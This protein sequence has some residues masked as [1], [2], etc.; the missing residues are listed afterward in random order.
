[1]D[2]KEKFTF[3]YTAPTEEERREIDGIRRQYSPAAAENDKLARLRTLDRRV[4]R[5]P[6]AAALTASII[7][8]LVFGTGLAMVLEWELVLGGVI[9]AALGAA[10]AAT[11]YPLRLL[12]SKR[13]KK[14]YGDEILRLCDELTPR[15]NK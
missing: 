11:A 5:L 10:L 14:T 3:S 7:G 12:L 2:K 13:L 8:V 15:E 6:F 4:R 1:M 9:V